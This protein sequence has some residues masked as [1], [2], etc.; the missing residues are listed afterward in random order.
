MIPVEDAYRKA[1]IVLELDEIPPYASVNPAVQR[2][3]IEFTSVVGA[4][5]REERAKEERATKTS[6]KLE[7]YV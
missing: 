4:I 2:K 1:L 6:K 7:E 5:L 3:R